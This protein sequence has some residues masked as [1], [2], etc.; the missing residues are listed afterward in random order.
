MG[1]GV[2]VPRT[3]DQ[4]RGRLG[5]GQM[6]CVDP[7]EGGLQEH[8]EIESQHPTQSRKAHAHERDHAC[9]RVGV[10]PLDRRELRVVY[11]QR[12]FTEHMLACVERADDL[13]DVSGAA[14]EFDELTDDLRRHRPA[15]PS[16][17]RHAPGRLRRR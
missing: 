17:A 11:A 14:C 3:T 15:A 1:S 6:V 16:A 2:G 12:L 4:G 9:H 13:G 10:D 7:S 8:A 5:P